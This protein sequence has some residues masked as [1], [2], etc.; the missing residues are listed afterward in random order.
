MVGKKGQRGSS[1][2]AVRRSVRGRKVSNRYVMKRQ[3]ESVTSAA[4]KLKMSED[5]Y[6][7][8]VDAAFG[9]RFID[10]VSVFTA[11][12]NF[13]VCKECGTQIKFL[14]TAQRGLGFKVSVICDMCSPRYILSSPLIDNHAYDINRRL[15]F[16]MRLLGIGVNGITKFCAFMCLPKPVFHSFYDKVIAKIAL[17]TRAVRDRC[18][19]KAASKETELSIQNNQIGGITV[20]GDGTWKKRGFSSL[21]GVTT[22]IG[23][24]TGKIVDLE[25]KSK[26]CKKC[27]YWKGKEDTAEFQDWVED[28]KEICD[29]NHVGSSG[30]MEVDSVVEM[31]QRSEEKHNLKYCFYV[32]DGDSK[33]FKGIMD[34]QPY[35]SVIVTKKECV[36]HVQK[37]MGTR[38]RNLKKKTPAD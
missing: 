8:N 35:D 9:Y 25:V 3:K 30:K 2:R 31:F 32:G 37:R 18:F 12:S 11:I 33:T 20:S 14:E 1:Y 4:K 19:S 27:S 16:V 6:N 24:R 26:I 28:H 10:F 15:V 22:L 7:I 36:D 5:D 38:L 34:A 21:L 23:W 13:V 17:A 29:I